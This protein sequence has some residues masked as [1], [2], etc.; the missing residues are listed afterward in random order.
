MPS[1]VIS[2]SAWITYGQCGPEYAARLWIKLYCGHTIIDHPVIGGYASAKGWPKPTA[3][4]ENLPPL[5]RC[6]ECE[7]IIECR[8][9]AWMAYRRAAD[10]CAEGHGK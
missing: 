1:D 2:H 8:M 9:A 7:R 3:I 10:D 5:F 6:H 4:R